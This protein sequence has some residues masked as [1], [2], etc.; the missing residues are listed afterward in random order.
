MRTFQKAG[1]Q[2]LKKMISPQIVMERK[3]L[4]ALV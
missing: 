4:E 1:L 2:I 3:W